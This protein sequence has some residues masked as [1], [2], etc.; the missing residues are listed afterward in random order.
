[1][2]FEATY[3]GDHMG[4]PVKGVIESF[5]ALLQ[6][7]LRLLRAELNADARF[8]AARVGS[9]IAFVFLALV[10]YLFLWFAVCTFAAHW[11]PLELAYALAGLAHLATGVFG[12]LKQAEALKSKQIFPVSA[13]EAAASGTALFKGIQSPERVENNLAP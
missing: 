1:M 3:K 2:V 4:P 13:S 5:G 12:I 8:F 11:I 6:A 9:S 7:H 10:G